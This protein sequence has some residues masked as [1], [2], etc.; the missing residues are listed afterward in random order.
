MSNIR[1]LLSGSHQTVNP[2][3]L[4]PPTLLSRP[5]NLG[6]QGGPIVYNPGGFPLLP[7]HTNQLA[8]FNMTDTD[9]T[10]WKV[11]YSPDGVAGDEVTMDSVLSPFYKW[12][13]R[14]L[15]KRDPLMNSTPRWKLKAASRDGNAWVFESPVQVSEISGDGQYTVHRGTASFRPTEDQRPLSPAIG[16]GSNTDESRAVGSG[17]SSTPDD[18]ETPIVWKKLPH[19]PRLVPE[20]ETSVLHLENDIGRTDLSYSIVVDLKPSAEP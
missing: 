17:A 11:F 15:S 4:L 18:G 10:T 3:R 12:E 2:F 13:G 9:N 20:E 6:L 14:S 5:L 7:S 8:T 16:G 19:R 1:V